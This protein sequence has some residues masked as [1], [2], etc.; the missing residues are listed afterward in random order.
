MAQF[1]DMSG[2]VLSYFLHRAQDA[3]RWRVLDECGDVVAS[4]AALDQASADA[5][6][7]AAMGLAGRGP[8]GL[9]HDG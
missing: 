8:H 7:L 3:W 9:T 5:G 6:A 2:P 1:L 4:G